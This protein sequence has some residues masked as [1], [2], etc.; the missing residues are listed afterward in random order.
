MFFE[1]FSVGFADVFIA[2]ASVLQTEGRLLDAAQCY[3][4]AI[5]VDALSADAR[6]GHGSILLLLGSRDLAV[7]EL[8]CALNLE[9]DHPIAAFQLGRIT[10]ALSLEGGVVSSAAGEQADYTLDSEKAD[11][12]EM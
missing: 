4:M 7:K 3:E 1:Q 12:N 8:E 11:A 2:L 5:D 9:S 10:T 6:V